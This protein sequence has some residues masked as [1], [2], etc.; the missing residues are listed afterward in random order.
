MGCASMFV[1]GK[2]RLCVA[3]QISQALCC[4][5]ELFRCEQA[6]SFFK[7]PLSAGQ[8]ARLLNFPPG[9]VPTPGSDAP[10]TLH[11]AFLYVFHGQSSDRAVTKHPVIQTITEISQSCIAYCFVCSEFLSFLRQIPQHSLKNFRSNK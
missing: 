6:F 10:N 2:I 3:R 5:R 7:V 8:S 9:G 1:A 11:G 4:K